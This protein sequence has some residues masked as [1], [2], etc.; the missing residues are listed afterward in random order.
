MARAKLRIYII[1]PYIT[2]VDLYTPDVGK[3]FSTLTEV[4]V[5]KVSN[6][7]SIIYRADDIKNM[8]MDILGN[9]IMKL[10][11]TNLPNTMIDVDIMYYYIIKN[12][13]TDYE[14]HY[15]IDLK[16]VDSIIKLEKN[17]IET[18]LPNF[19]YI[20]NKFITELYQRI[21]EKYND[22]DED[23]DDEDTDDEDDIYFNDFLTGITDDD[24]DDEDDIY[25]DR[26]SAMSPFDFIESNIK[27]SNNNYHT[28]KKKHRKEYAQ[29]R[30]L[31]DA[32]NAKRSY[33]RHGVIICSDKSSK[34]KDMKIIKEFL[35][36]FF[37]GN[38]NWI[39]EF[40]HDVLCRWMKMYS[41][42]KK[43]LKELEKTHRKAQN[44][45]R[46]SI[47]TEKTLDFT[48]RLFNVPID[49]WDDPSK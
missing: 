19:G 1:P 17:F 2:G 41:I 32:K 48:R 4:K 45:K 33:N 10:F 24:D 37:P 16:V 38:S 47:K 39:K 15:D 8:D 35:K 12:E 3:I 18:N 7:Y 44:A 9:N 28:P 36:D 29:S 40:R 27:G 23:L 43:D 14:P 5:N 20:R 34:K 42:S 49:R 11:M 26:I 6:G 22:I 13:N 25:D 46:N 21:S 31:Y 30:I